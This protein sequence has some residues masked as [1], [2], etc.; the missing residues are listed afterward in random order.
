MIVMQLTTPKQDGPKAAS[1]A[2]TLI[3]LLVVIAIISLL[4]AI[5]LPSLAAA[6]RIA[7]RTSCQTNLKNL[8][9]A[10]HMYLDDNDDRFLQSPNPTDNVQV[11]YGGKQGAIPPFR[12]R[13]P[14]NRYLNLDLELDD[15]P[16]YF[17][18]QDEGAFTVSGKHYDY[19]GTS[20][21]PNLMM[22]GTM[23]LQITGS[24][25]CADVLQQANEKLPGLK[26]TQCA[27]PGRLVLIGD[28]GWV[29]DWNV[30]DPINVAWRHGEDWKH[31]VAFLDGHVAFQKFDKGRHTSSEYLVMPLRNLQTACAE[32]QAQ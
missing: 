15:A 2:F 6:R 13:K 16:V 29:Y 9:E 27:D 21:S 20:Y 22:I 31:N 14:L 23:P 5:L 3:E 12:K 10:W 1:R 4:I 7:D 17:C 8:A 19:F 28:Y 32:C 25:P 18:K 26:R 11:N 24:D 30:N